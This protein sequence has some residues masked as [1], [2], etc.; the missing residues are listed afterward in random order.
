MSATPHPILLLGAASCVPLASGATAQALS[1]SSRLP[2][3]SY[4]HERIRRR[5]K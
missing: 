5:H 4:A 1:A 3:L 2:Q